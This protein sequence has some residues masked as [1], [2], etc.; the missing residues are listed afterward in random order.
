MYFPK[1]EISYETNYRNG[2]KDGEEIE[3]SENGKLKNKRT[4]KEGE[5]FNGGFNENVGELIVNLNYVNGIKEGETIA[6]NE[7][8]QIVAKGIY[9]KVN[10]TMELLLLKLAIMLQ[11]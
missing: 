11:N 6:K 5:S 4:Y 10:H 2:L 8:Q 7:D 9:K 3:F 1:G